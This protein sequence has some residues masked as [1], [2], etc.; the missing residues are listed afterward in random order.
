MRILIKNGYVIDPVTGREGKFDVLTEDTKIVRVTETIEESE[1][2]A[3]R[4]V[5]ATGKH[6]LP[7]FIDL[8]VHFR[9]PGLE[10]KETIATGSAAAADHA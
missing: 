3:D 6:V 9:E 1:A 4:V 10:Y 7:G 5:D 2:K 8:H